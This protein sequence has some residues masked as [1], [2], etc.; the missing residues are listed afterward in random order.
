MVGAAAWERAVLDQCQHS[1]RPWPPDLNAAEA[2][3]RRG[4]RGLGDG[5]GQPSRWVTLRAYASL[6]RLVASTGS[7]VERCFMM[8]SS[9]RPA[10]QASWEDLQTVF[11]TRGNA[12]ISPV[13][14]RPRC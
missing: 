10:S 14:A 11:G 3:L 13:P 1:T 4:Q 8:E 5:E 2:G 12:P 6:R 7:H 9:D